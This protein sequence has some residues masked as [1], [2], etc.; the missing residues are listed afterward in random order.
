[1]IRRRRHLSLL[2]RL[3]EAKIYPDC[4]GRAVHTHHRL[5]RSQGGSDDPE[6]LLDV[7]A[8]CHQ[9]IHDHPAEAYLRGLLIRGHDAT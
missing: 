8:P 7:C 2:P 1:M 4:D 5:L 9:W 3:C 6:N